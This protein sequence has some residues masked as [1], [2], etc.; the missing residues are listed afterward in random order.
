MRLYKNLILIIF[1]LSGC[2]TMKVN[3]VADKM[4]NKNYCIGHLD[5][6]F[7][8]LYKFNYSYGGTNS[9][10]TV[11]I[12]YQIDFTSENIFVNNNFI[13]IE[14]SG[15][16]KNDFNVYSIRNDSIIEKIT[17]NQLDT[18]FNKNNFYNITDSI[19]KQQYHFYPKS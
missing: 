16:R 6:T 11:I 1:I 5:N 14:K 7:I 12:W 2:I 13:I 3:I 19:K 9:K 15:K 4:I 10:D 17:T 18:F 8:G